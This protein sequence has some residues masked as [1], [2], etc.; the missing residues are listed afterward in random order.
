MIDWPK[1]VCFGEPAFEAGERAIVGGGC[2]DVENFRDLPQGIRDNMADVQ[3]RQFLTYC[4][5]RIR[6]EKLSGFLLRE[7]F[8]HVGQV[9]G[10]T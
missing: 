2:P 4:T 7:G 5:D 9:C 3:N 1:L 6:C 10:T 8:T